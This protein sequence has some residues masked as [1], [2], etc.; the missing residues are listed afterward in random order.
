MKISMLEQLTLIFKDRMRFKLLLLSLSMGM[1]GASIMP[2]LST[3][4]ALNMGIEPLWIGFIFA[5]NTL[6]GI[7]VS[8]W[9]ANHSDSGL[10]RLGII[11]NGAWISFFSVIGLGVSTHY[12]VLMVTGMA[13][14]AAVSPIQPQIFAMARDLVEEEDAALFQSLLRASISFSW[15]IG[16]PLAYILFSL[17]GFSGLSFICAGIFLLSL[18]SLKGFQDAPLQVKTTEVKLTDPRLKWLVL[19]MAAVFAA[20]NMYIVY[21]PIYLQENLN[22]VAVIPGLLMG[23][24]AGLEIPMMIYTGAR[25][26]HWPLFSPLKFAALMGVVFYS[27]IF[28]SQNLSILFMA[29]LFNGAFIGIMAGLGISVFQALMKGRMGM[30]STLYTNAIR[31]GGLAGALGGGVLAQMIGIRGVFVACT[32]MAIIAFMALSKASQLKPN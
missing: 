27:L 16:P 9:I 3:H 24:T 12:I 22:F 30:A 28:F 7:V 1:A 11:Q 4:L 20:N 5:A 21:M 17:I 29:Q 14:F 15:I 23:F 32:L 31:M 19:A 6:S 25:S 10:S 26:N 13:L 18:V 8:H 2:V